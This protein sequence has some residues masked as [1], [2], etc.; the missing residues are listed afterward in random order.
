M[1]ELVNTFVRGKRGARASGV[2]L[3]GLG[4]FLIISLASYSM[5]DYP[6]SSRPP[7]EGANWG[8]RIGAYVSYGAFMGIGYAAYIM[9]LLALFWGWNRLRCQPLLRMVS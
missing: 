4:I 9:P 7:E 5:Q 1:A 8:G 6:N 2:L 3:V